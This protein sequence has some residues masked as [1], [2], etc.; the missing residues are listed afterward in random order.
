MEKTPIC[1]AI[2]HDTDSDSVLIVQSFRTDIGSGEPQS[3]TERVEITP[4]ETVRVP[5]YFGGTLVLSE[6]R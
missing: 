2:T 5:L 6:P 4:G 1:V 3:L